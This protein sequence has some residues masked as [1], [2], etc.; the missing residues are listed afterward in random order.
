MKTFIFKVWQGYTK[1]NLRIYS[2]SVSFYIIVSSV[3]LVA[4]LFYILSF[5]SQDLV[6][7][8]EILISSIL[9]KE[10]YD[11]F[12]SVILS[13]KERSNI[14]LVPFSIITAL[15]GSTKGIGGICEGIEHIFKTQNKGGF[16]IRSV[17]R[18]WRTLLFYL[19]IMASLFVFAFGKLFYP[20]KKDVFLIKLFLQLRIFFFAVILFMFFLILYAR[21][22]N[23]KIK[24]QILGS[25]F[26]S[27]GWMVFTYFYSIYVGYAVN[28]L[29]VYAEMGTVI[30]FMLWVYFCVNIILIGAEI[31]K[32]FINKK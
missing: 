25:V 14:A 21:L 19:I 13:I 5:M 32:H 2:S 28:S 8:F 15:W 30:F 22:S 11:N 7:N 16:I 3:P 20:Y 24:A 17:E 9:P 1:D 4:I 31:N 27:L 12:Y 26:A 18:I 10:I 29:S 23:G 6:S